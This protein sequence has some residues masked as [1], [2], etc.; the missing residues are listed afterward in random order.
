MYDLLAKEQIN[1]EVR[2][3]QAGRPLELST[4]ERTLKNALQSMENQIEATKARLEAGKAERNNL[5][6]KLQR[7]SAD[8]D[9]SRQRLQALQKVR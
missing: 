1:K 5:T 2:Q 7:K 8:L 3:S 4:V 6:L 9:R